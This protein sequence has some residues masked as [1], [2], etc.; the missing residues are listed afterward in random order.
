MD[1]VEETGG[2]ISSVLP[3]KA[4]SNKKPRVIEYW[5]SHAYGGP[6]HCLFGLK[7]F[8]AHNESATAAV[9]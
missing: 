9:L 4:L 1:V 7:V 2:L 5:C 8:L 6:S 3:N